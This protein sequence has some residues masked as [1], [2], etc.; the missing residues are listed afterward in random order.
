[1][2][3]RLSHLELQVTD[4]EA[5]V[6][7]A[8][9]VCRLRVSDRED[10]AAFLSTSDRHHEL[11]L[12]A[13]KRPACRRV[14]FEYDDEAELSAVR[15]RAQAEGCEIVEP[16]EAQSESVDRRFLFAG[17]DGQIFE[18]LTGMARAASRDGQ[19]GDPLRPR[20]FGHVSMKSPDPPRLADFLTR[21]VGLRVSD[22][23]GRQAL[24]LRADAQH[25]GIA[26]MREPGGIH[27]Y[28]FEVDGWASF[29]PVADHL[30]AHGRPLIWGP[31]RHGPG[32]NLFA[33]FLDP[34]GCVVEY[35]AELEQIDDEDKHEPGD[36]PLTP[37]TFN[38]WGP[39]SP[40]GWHDHGLPYA[41]LEALVNQ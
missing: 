34:E 2:T 39:S 10:G 29:Q 11:V 1:V 12:R 36:W 19:D 13:G 5:S 3:V 25:H 31:G 14:A 24:W 26:I 4:L 28:A 38:V 21:V 6:R 16:P 32:N 27:H 41:P 33:Y 37:D 35:Y 18:A 17:P 7:F 8:T 9:D 30:R 20:A 23:A 15:D 40:V 22:R